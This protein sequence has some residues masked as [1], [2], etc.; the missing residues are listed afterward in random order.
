M[1]QDQDTYD[2]FDQSGYLIKK[3]DNHLGSFVILN[4]EDC[5]DLSELNK[6]DLNK[7]E[8]QDILHNYK[9]ITTSCTNALNIWGLGSSAISIIRFFL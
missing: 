7:I 2:T 5:K 4:N 6:K 8:Q 9:N 1:N 3:T